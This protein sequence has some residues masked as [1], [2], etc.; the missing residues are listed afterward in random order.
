MLKAYEMWLIKEYP[1]FKNRLKE[2][3]NDT[4][5]VLNNIMKIPL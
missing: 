5:L 1:E 3:H 2:V 4:M